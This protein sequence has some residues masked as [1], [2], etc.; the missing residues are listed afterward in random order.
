[1]GLIMM[2]GIVVSSG[3]LLVDFANVRRRCTASAYTLVDHAKEA[4]HA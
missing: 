4:A 3:V 1:M 2:A